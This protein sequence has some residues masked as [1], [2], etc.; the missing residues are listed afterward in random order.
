MD[1][2]EVRIIS[3]QVKGGERV[4]LYSPEDPEHEHL[5]VHPHVV[6]KLDEWT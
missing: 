5:I 3:Q 1:T 4:M 2:D 6:L